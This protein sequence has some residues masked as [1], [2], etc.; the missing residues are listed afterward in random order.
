M[1]E[2]TVSVGSGEVVPP[3][4]RTV[5]GPA[6]FGVVAELGAVSERRARAMALHQGP[7]ADARGTQLW[8]EEQIHQLGERIANGTANADMRAAFRRCMDALSKLNAFIDARQTEIYAQIDGMDRFLGWA[9][10]NSRI[11]AIKARQWELDQ[12][13]LTERELTGVA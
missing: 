8:Y 12:T 7:L 9:K 4:R 3:S 11:D 2:H 13:G 10:Q 6:Q 5:T 1:V